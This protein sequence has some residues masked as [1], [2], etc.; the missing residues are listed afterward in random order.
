MPSTESFSALDGQGAKRLLREAMRAAKDKACS[1]DIYLSEGHIRPLLASI[2]GF[3]DFNAMKAVRPIWSPC[4]SSPLA[5][6]LG[7][8]GRFAHPVL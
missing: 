1:E 7:A 5:Q 6:L 8:E 4:K 2:F 3:E